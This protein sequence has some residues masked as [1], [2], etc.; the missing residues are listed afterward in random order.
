ME[1]IEQLYS[2]QIAAYGS[3]SMNKISKLKILI[4]G[5]RGLGIEITKNII[6]AGPEKVTI[7]DN[8]KII[9]EDL[10]SNFYV[11]E[12]DIGSRRDE[13]CLNKLCELNDRVKCDYLKA[14]KLEEYINEYDIIIITE[15]LEIEYIIKLDRICRNNKKGFIYCLV[16]GLSF[17]CF[18]DFGEHVINNTSNNDIRKY[19]IKDIKKGKNTIITIDNEF[20]NF[21][22]NEDEYVILKKIMGMSQLMDGKKRKILNCKEDRFEIDED[23]TNYEDYMQGG[24]VEEILENTTINNKQ[25]E[26]MLKFPQQ[27]EYVNQANIEINMHLAFLSLHD[28]YKEHKRLPENN[29]DDLIQI[30]DITK[31][32]YIKN[33]KEWCKGIN[34]EEEFLNDIYKYSKCEISPVCGYGGGVVSQEIIKYIGIY[35]PINQWFR[36]EFSGILDKGINH[37]SLI[38][39]SRYNYQLLIFG[40]E[41]QKKLE[42]FNIKNIY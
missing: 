17:Y 29:K 38:K 9:K 31:K 4:Y 7:F 30:F 3:N 19:F 41:S 28:F 6:L 10:G 15:I 40:D 21:D 42:K 36:A 22:L 8:N 33:L 18:V 11:E 26:E 24:I 32:I 13:I 35:Q 27:C 1:D 39:D 2:R 23:S 14:G 25:F 16:F 12:K 5:I 20:D 37:D 34:L